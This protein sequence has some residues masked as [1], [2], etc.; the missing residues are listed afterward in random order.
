MNFENIDAAADQQAAIENELFVFEK[1]EAVDQ[2]QRQLDY[3]DS[4]L[5]F[6]HSVNNLFDVVNDIIHP[7]YMSDIFDE[8]YTISECIQQKHFLNF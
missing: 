6:D 7:S 3:E 4:R 1:D 2:E 8:A 5:E